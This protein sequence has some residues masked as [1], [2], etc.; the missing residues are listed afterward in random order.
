MLSQNHF[1]PFQLILI[2]SVSLTNHAAHLFHHTKFSSFSSLYNPYEPN[3]Y[4]YLH[5]DYEAYTVV[6]MEEYDDTR[7]SEFEQAASFDID[8]DEVVM[9]CI[10]FYSVFSRSQ[11]LT[12]TVLLSVSDQIDG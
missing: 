9:L 1:T 10:G 7:H 4:F 6:T 5:A 11:L 3:W 12:A 8:E 2:C